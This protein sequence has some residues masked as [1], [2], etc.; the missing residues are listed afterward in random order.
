MKRIPPLLL[1][2]ALLFAGNAD[3]RRDAVRQDDGPLPPTLAATGFAATGD[4]AAGFAATRPP[5]AGKAVSLP[6]KPLPFSPQYP[7]WTDG[8]DKARW[9]YLPPGSAIDAAR[10]DAWEFPVGTRLWKQ[11][12]FGGRPVETRYMEKTR[13]GWRFATYLWNADGSAA[14]LAPEREVRV[15]V[16][17]APGGLHIVPSRRDCLAC[18]GSAPVPVLGLTALQLS[19]DRD[20]L[21]PGAGRHAG[22]D[23]RTLAA[24]GRL[25]NLPPALL[26]QPPRIVA[27]TPVE[28]AALGY[29]HGNCSHCHNTSSR[30]APLSLT[31]AQ[32]AADPAASRREVLQSVLDR[33]GRYG[34]SDDA[35]V[36]A[37]VAPGL[38]DRSLLIAR[39]RSR[40]PHLQ[41]P[42]LGT[43]APDTQALELLH[44]WIGELT[45]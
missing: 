17:G 35:V 12:S 22:T 15:R 39:M 43:S 23:L 36:D 31:L 30:A 2:L 27:D 41:M 28:R 19:P 13:R 16:A 18:H 42:P 10:P 40:Q 9:L 25:R 38:P 5:A 6:G 44:R 11:F 34:Q 20:P 8:A 29:L 14:T 45:H 32:R 26:K 3:A 24:S 21:A 7:L 1:T 33:H 4:P 37:I